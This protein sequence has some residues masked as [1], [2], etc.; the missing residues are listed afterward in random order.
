LNCTLAVN[1]PFCMSDMYAREGLANISYRSL[2]VLICTLLLIQYLACVGVAHAGPE[3]PRFIDAIDPA[4]IFPGADRLGSATGDPPVAPA[5]KQ[6]EQL[7]FVFLTSDYMNTTGYSGKPIHQL[8]ALDMQGI[9]RKV[10]LVEHHEPIVLIGIPEQRIVAVLGDY[11]GM[12]VG[13]LVRGSLEHDVDIVTGAT[14]TVMVMDDTI[15]RSA[16]KVARNFGLSGLRAEKKKPG[17][18]HQ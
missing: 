7:G 14:V 9:I 11:E 16:I 18:W 4:E 15:L 5:F 2:I 8:V 6:G 12:D 13:K 1:I 3:L 17:R 10:L